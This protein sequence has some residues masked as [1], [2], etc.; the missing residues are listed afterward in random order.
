MNA[1]IAMLAY[2]QHCGFYA[3]ALPA[4]NLLMNTILPRL[5]V[6]PDA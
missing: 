2:K 1:S 6:E 3:Q 5:F 4:Y